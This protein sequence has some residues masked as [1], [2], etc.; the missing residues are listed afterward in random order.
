MKL[1]KT[2][3]ESEPKPVPKDDKDVIKQNETQVAKVDEKI[4]ESEPKSVPGENKDKKSAEDEKKDDKKKEDVIIDDK[5]SDII[6]E[7]PKIEETTNKEPAKEEPVEEKVKEIKENVREMSKLDEKLLELKEDTHTLIEAVSDKVVID[8]IEVREHP[9]PVI[10]AESAPE[11]PDV[12]DK[13]TK[14][15]IDKC[16]LGRK[17]PKE[18]EE[19]VLKIV[20]KVAEVLKSDAP[21][22]EFEGKIPITLPPYTA[23]YTTELRETHITTCDSPLVENKPI[24]IDDIPPIPEE[25]STPKANESFEEEPKPNDQKRSSLIKESQE[26]MMATS[27]IISDIKSNKVEETENKDEPEIDSGTVHRMLVT[28]S[29]EDGGEEIEICPPGTITFSRS[30]ESSGRSSPDLQKTSQK[31]SV[32]DT[33]SDTLSTVRQV[34]KNVEDERKKQL[35]MRKK[36]H[37]LFLLENHRLN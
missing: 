7:K 14:D 25:P 33:I 29:S 22:E 21:L 9:E 34:Q 2:T 26:L 32:V 12:E 10:I 8:K 6:T 31:S 3:I 28:T 4:V 19:D 20:T 15:I 27:K 30:S 13:L 37:Q 23:A 35:M 11:T 5:V 18:R 36:D 16:E 17:S 1:E 24:K